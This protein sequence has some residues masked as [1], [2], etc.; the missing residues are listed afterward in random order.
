MKK[1]EEFATMTG[2]DVTLLVNDGKICKGFFSGHQ[3]KKIKTEKALSAILDS[4]VLISSS[5]MGTQ[6]SP[7]HPPAPL[8]QT[9]AAQ[10]T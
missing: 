3:E 10:R 4:P 9:T 5:N 8:A 2:C 1:A 7:Q 6:T